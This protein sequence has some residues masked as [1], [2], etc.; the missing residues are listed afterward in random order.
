MD[1][2][3]QGLPFVTTYIDDVLIHSPDKEVHKQHLQ[4]VF[5]RLQEAGLTLQGRK[6]HIA[7]SEVSCLGHVSAGQGMKPDSK[8]VKAIHDWPRPTDV[9]A[10]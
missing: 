3:M 1:K 6:C 9:T 8:K 4:Q 10:V 7:L 5:T 2:V